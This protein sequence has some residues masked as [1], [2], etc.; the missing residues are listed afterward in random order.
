VAVINVCRWNELGCG[1]IKAL[2]EAEYSG[3][4]F[5]LLK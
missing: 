5:V 3:G 1:L 2:L 4:S